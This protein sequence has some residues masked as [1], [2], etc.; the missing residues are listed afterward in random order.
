MV[1]K[2]VENK[3]AKVSAIVSKQGLKKKKTEWEDIKTHFK[4]QDLRGESITTLKYILRL[5]ELFENIKSG[6]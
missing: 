4:T 2:H 1:R 3:N 5:D 6:Y